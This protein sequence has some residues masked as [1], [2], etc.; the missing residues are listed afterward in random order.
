[1]GY[2]MEKR[3]EREENKKR[4]REKRKDEAVD[5]YNGSRSGLV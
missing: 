3:E 1:M 5:K 4:R 2:G